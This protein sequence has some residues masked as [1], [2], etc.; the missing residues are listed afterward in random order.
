M[1]TWML[2][3]M[4]SHDTSV[5]K[6]SLREIAARRTANTIGSRATTNDRL[7]ANQAEFVT[8]DRKA[9]ACGKATMRTSV[10]TSHAALYRTSGKDR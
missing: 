4:L 1:L 3:H 9:K 6:D 5:T 2:A 10:M 7:A 8:D